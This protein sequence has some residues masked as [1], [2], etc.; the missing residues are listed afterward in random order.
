MTKLDDATQSLVIERELSHPAEKVWRALT[1]GALIEDWLMKNDFQPVVGHK[2]NFRAT[3]MP[4]WNG[5]TDCEVLAV[6]PC[7]RLED[8][9]HLDTDADQRRCSLAHGTIRLSARGQ[10]QLSGCCLWLAEISRWIGACNGGSDVNSKAV[11]PYWGMTAK[12]W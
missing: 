2:F 3:P 7:Q 4:H 6:E 12:C 1:Q 8:D 9:R 5:V 10:A 11:K